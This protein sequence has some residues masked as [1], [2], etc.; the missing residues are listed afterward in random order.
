MPCYFLSNF[1]HLNFFSFSH[2]LV[3]KIVLIFS[4][5]KL[6]LLCRVASRIWRCYARTLRK[7]KKD[8]SHELLAESESMKA[9]RWW[10]KEPKVSWA[11]TINLFIITSGTSL[12]KQTW[13]PLDFGDSQLVNALGKKFG[14]ATIIKAKSHCIPSCFL[15]RRQPGGSNLHRFIHT[16]SKGS[17]S[18]QKYGFHKVVRKLE[19]QFFRMPWWHQFIQMANCMAFFKA[20]VQANALIESINPNLNW[21]LRAGLFRPELDAYWRKS[22]QYCFRACIFFATGLWYCILMFKYSHNHCKEDNWLE[23]LIYRENV[24]VISR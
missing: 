11:R 22:G 24:R 1:S 8:L 12:E 9:D 21:L 6:T 16:A 19:C 18:R 17:Q 2:I 5:A 23:N 14:L 7:R 20:W 10:D 15:F 4:L 13:T 3:T